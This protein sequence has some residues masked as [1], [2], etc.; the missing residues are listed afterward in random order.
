MADQKNGTDDSDVSVLLSTGPVR[1]SFLYKYL[2]A[3]SPVFLAIVSIVT[4]MIL[5]TLTRVA[6][7]SFTAAIPSY[8]A[9][10]SESLIRQYNAPIASA[11]NITILLIAPVGIFIFFI[12]FGWV[13]RHPELWTGTLLTLTLSAITG[14]LLAGSSAS[15]AF[16]GDFLLI[17]LQWIAFLVQPFCII[18]TLIVIFGIEKFRR[19][20]RYTIRKDGLFIHG[21]LWTMQNHMI[22]HHQIG[23]VVIEQDLFGRRFNFGTVIPQTT[24]RWGAVTSIRGVGTSGQ[25]DNI[26]AGIG[27]AQGREEASRQPLDCLFGIPGP[28]N[29]QKILTELIHQHAS[30]GEEQVEILKK[31]YD[32]GGTGARGPGPLPA[33][34]PPP[35][36]LGAGSGGAGVQGSRLTAGEKTPEQQGG[37]IVRV[38]DPGLPQPSTGPGN[39]YTREI[40]PVIRAEQKPAAPPPPPPANPSA[41]PAFYQIKKLAELRDKKIITEEEFLAK[42]AELLK[43]I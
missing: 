37:T 22:P 26:A 32:S 34:P 16:S 39:G 2:L 4:I 7:S 24:T 40:P 13:T 17:V 35:A 21:G 42:K 36:G 31:I 9:P 5:S 10:F 1:A 6:S 14:Y 27:F 41:D 12:A 25:K 8:M 38:S 43:R 3:A 20:I 28:Q 19:S 30:R 23:R 29:A 18:A 15:P 11:T 33:A